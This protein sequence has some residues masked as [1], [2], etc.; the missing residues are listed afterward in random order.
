M[1]KNRLKIIIITALILILGYSAY[2][3]LSGNDSKASQKQ[4]TDTPG[5]LSFYNDKLLYTSCWGGIYI[6]DYCRLVS[7][8]PFT[9]ESKIIHTT[10]DFQGGP[11]YSWDGKKIAYANVVPKR[12]AG[13]I[14]VMDADG[15][16][17]QQLTHDYNDDVKTTETPTGKV[18]RVK[19]NASPSFS[20]DG[21]RIIFKRASMKRQRILGYGDMY[22]SWDI[23]EINLETKVIR[24][25]THYQFYEMSRPFYLSDDKRFI[26]WGTSPIVQSLSATKKMDFRENYKRQY[27]DNNIFIMDGKK[28]DLR[29]AFTHGRWTSEPFVTK[30]DAILFLSITNEMDGLPPKPENYDLFL[31]KGDVITRVTKNQG[32]IRWPSISFDGKRI[33]FYVSRQKEEGNFGYTYIINSDGKGLTHI[34][35]PTIGPRKE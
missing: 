29:P 10:N 9:K 32:Y 22:T 4:E 11:I 23:F 18:M 28:N 2:R 1:T 8:D 16:N 25:L 3:Q 24:Q 26:F 14:C 35:Y 13:N 12:N 19:Y 7:Y 27:R 17:H 33:T 30:D 34:S 21:K 5:A 31:K 20:R 15:S 6:T